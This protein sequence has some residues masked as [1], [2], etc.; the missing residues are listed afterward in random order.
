MHIN[1]IHIII[2]IGAGFIGS[3]FARRK[4]DKFNFKHLAAFIGVMVVAIVLVD[5]FIGR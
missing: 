4:K 3:F 2:A 1:I 5:M